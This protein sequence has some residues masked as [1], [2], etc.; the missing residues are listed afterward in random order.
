[1]PEEKEI[2]DLQLHDYISN[3]PGAIGRILYE[4]LFPRKRVQRSI[5]RG[6]GS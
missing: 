4:A 3:V 1:M 2:E 6:F 5:L